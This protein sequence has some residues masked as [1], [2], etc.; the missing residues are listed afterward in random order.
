MAY[1]PTVWE[2]REVEFARRYIMTTNEDGT[3]TLTPSEGQVFA[4]GTPLDAANLN[5]LEQQVEANDV[6]K[7][8]LSGDTMT[9]NLTAPIF[10][11]TQELQQNGKSLAN[12]YQPKGSY[13]ATGQYPTWQADPNGVSMVIGKYNG[14]GKPIR[15]FL[16]A[17]QPAASS[18][19]HRVWIQID[20]F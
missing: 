14:T 6:N 1:E 12:T 8:N 10:N 2:N 3:V 5:K 18:T 9:G 17:S 20:N 4:N 11:A 16:T 7:V 15:L 19:E 13:Q